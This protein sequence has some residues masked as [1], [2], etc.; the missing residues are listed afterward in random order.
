MA[1][2]VSNAFFFGRGELDLL[3]LLLVM[4]VKKDADP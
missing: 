3:G 4:L 2:D 1:K